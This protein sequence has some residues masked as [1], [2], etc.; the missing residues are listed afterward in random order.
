MHDAMVC[1]LQADARECSIQAPQELLIEVRPPPVSDE[2]KFARFPRDARK[3]LIELR[4]IL[5]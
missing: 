4:Q 3:D 1:G 5:E 2:R